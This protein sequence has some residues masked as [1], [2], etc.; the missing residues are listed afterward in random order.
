MALV[1]EHLSVA[2]LEARYEA[3]EDVTSLRHF[4]TIFLLA[5]RH[6]TRPVAEITS[7]GQRWFEHLLERCMMYGPA[8]LGDLRRDNR[9]VATLRKPQLLE[10][11]RVRLGEPPPDGGHWTSARA[12]RWMADDLARKR[13]APNATGKR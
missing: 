3:C 11:L 8:A 13:S 9:G 4:H 5:R 7:F 10:R 2:D 1:A 6:S 12:A